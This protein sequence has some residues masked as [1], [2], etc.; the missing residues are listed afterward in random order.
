MAQ[1]APDANGYHPSKSAR[2][3]ERTNR[4][5]I[6]ARFVLEEEH[7]PFPYSTSHS[8]SQSLKEVIAFAPG[9]QD[10]PH[11]WSNRK[12]SFVVFNGVALVMSSTIGSSIA[13]GAS[14]QFA[15]FFNITSQAQLV[16]PTSSYL[17]GYVVGPL[18]F[19]PL[20][21]HHGRKK[22]MILTFALFSAFTLGCALAPNFVALCVF[23]LLVGI[24]A[25]SPISVVGGIYADIYPDPVTRG[26]ALTIF[27]T[28]TTFGPILGP[29]MS[30]FIAVVSWRWIFWL[31][32]IIAGVTW[33]ILLLSSE[34]YAPV[35]L[36]TRAQ[37]LRKEN[38][39]PNI[40]APLELEHRD[41]RQLITVVLTRPV[42]MFLSEALVLCS[43]LYLSFVYAI[44]YMY[45]QAYPTIFEGIYHF[46]SGEVG[47]TFL[48]IGVGAL[49]ACGLYLYWDRVLERAKARDPPAAWSQSEEYRRLPLACIGGPLLML[50]CFW[51]GWTARESI[52][53]AVP[54]LSALPFGMGFLLLFMSLINY[55]VDAYEVFAASAMAASACSRSLFGAVLPFA[56]RPMYQ[57]LGV[58]WACSL[59]GFLSLA[60]CAIPFVFIRYG[61]TI[62]EK[63]SFC[64][65]LKQCKMQENEQRQVQERRMQ[66]EGRSGVD[67]AIAVEKLV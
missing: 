67:E 14:H 27:M 41:M 17:V 48:P 31:S 23:R 65:Y 26:R 55:L 58:A 66:Q 13:A 37:R 40:F 4:S 54:V 25:S 47:L 51:L 49:L 45:F 20:S 60:M 61:N 57:R 3:H 15:T 32:L 39:N 46:N 64:Q 38:N 52:H 33:P 36:V 56:A 11:N 2:G 5:D 8:S 1:L 53:W 24:G 62:R 10:N 35:I 21:E 30:G 18:L 7:S 6:D 59:L 43:C 19:G 12:K 44:F 22:I 63:S 29:I 9:D 16:L 50:S 28:A 34:T 42:R